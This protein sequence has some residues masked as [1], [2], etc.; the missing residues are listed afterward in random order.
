MCEK[1]RHCMAD[2]VCPACR[3]ERI[4]R[5]I[6]E[7]DEAR[8][9]VNRREATE[10]N[11]LRLMFEYDST[12]TRLRLA[13]AVCEAAKKWKQAQEKPDFVMARHNFGRLVEALS[14]WY[15]AKKG[16]NNAV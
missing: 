5:L 2:Q 10:R 14:A 3:V 4:S 7:R 9:E 1:H 11:Y 13:E 12:L 15:A 6:R 8:A 16:D